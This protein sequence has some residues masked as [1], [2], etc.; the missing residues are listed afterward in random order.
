MRVLSPI[1]RAVKLRVMFAPPVLNSETVVYHL[2]EPPP[3]SSQRRP[4][5]PVKSMAKHTSR[6]AEAGSPRR[7]VGARR[8]PPTYQ[9]RTPI[10]AETPIA[11]SNRP[12]KS[13]RL[14]RHAHSQG[15]R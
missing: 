6:L 12:C 3:R 1:P 4:G 14:S 2:R 8:R 10:D 9:R 11:V 13:V 15:D 5:E 7:G